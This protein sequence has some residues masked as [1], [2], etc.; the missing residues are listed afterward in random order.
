[1]RF[2]V[3][4]WSVE[5]WWQWAALCPEP[6]LCSFWEGGVLLSA[7]TGTALKGNHHHCASKGDLVWSRWLDYLLTTHCG[8][9]S[10]VLRSILCAC[11]LDVALWLILCDLQVRSHCDHIVA[12]GGLQLL[13]RVYQL[14]TDSMKIQRNI[15]RII[16]NLALN[17]GAHQ[18]IAQSGKSVTNLNKLETVLIMCNPDWVR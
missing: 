4:G 5:F 3:P 13:Q 17:E 1:M 12:N 8:H 6:Y 15:V 7:G 18:A 11:C 9:C 2:I 10:S 16:G 14:R